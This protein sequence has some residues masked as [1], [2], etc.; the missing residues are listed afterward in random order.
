M[1]VE[2]L[3]RTCDLWEEEYRRPVVAGDAGSSRPCPPLDGHQLGHQ[4]KRT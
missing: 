3:Q 2:P 1:T 4:P